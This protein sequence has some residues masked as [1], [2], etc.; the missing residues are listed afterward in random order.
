MMEAL[1][2]KKIRAFYIFGEN[3]ANSEPDIHKVE[4]ELAS[5]RISRLPG[6]FPDRDHEVCTCDFPCGRLE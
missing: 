6:Y 4:H 5:A 1:P 3:M 2:S